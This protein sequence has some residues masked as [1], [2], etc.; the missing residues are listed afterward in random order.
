MENKTELLLKVLGPAL[1]LEDKRRLKGIF[2]MY[3]QVYHGESESVWIR[4]F[5]IAHILVRDMG[6]GVNTVLGSLVTGLLE[7][8]KAKREDVL[9]LVGPVA[10]IIADGLNQIHRLN[11][12][13]VSIASENFRRLLL[14][15]APDIRSLL[16]AMAENLHELQHFFSIDEERKQLALN[17]AQHIFIPFAH[18]LGLYHMKSQLEDLH[19]RYSLPEVYDNIMKQIAELKPKQESVFRSFIAPIRKALAV[20]GIPCEFKWRF[21]SIPSIY[22][23]MQK[24]EVPLEQVYDLFAIRII[25]QGQLEDEKAECWRV[26]S[27]VSDIYKPDTSRLRDWITRPKASGY[28]SLHTTVTTPEGRVVEVQIRT[29]R[30]DE[31]AEKGEAAHWRYKE[32]GRGSEMDNWM[33]EIRDVLE[34]PVPEQ[35]E[36]LVSKTRPADRIF[37]LTP[38]GD[39]RDLPA[40]ASVLDFAFDIHS[41]LGA[42]CTGARVNGRV[43]PI[44]HILSNGDVVEILTSRNQFPKIDW[45]QFCITSKARNRIKRA[46][47]EDRLKEAEKGKADLMRRCRNW[48]VPYTDELIERLLKYFKFK[49]ALDLYASLSKE[50]IDWAELKKVAS[51]G[52][53]AAVIPPPLPKKKKTEKILNAPDDAIV[54]GDNTRNISYTLAKCCSPIYGDD[55]FG[56][57][58]ISRGITIHRKNCPNAASLLSRHEYRIVEARWYEKAGEGPYTVQ[59]RITGDDRL[60]LLADLTNVLTNE[61][62]INILSVSLNSHDGFFDGTMKLQVRNRVQLD[63]V[64]HRLLKIK[65]VARVKR[66]FD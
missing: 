37:V 62:K 17:T 27:I 13:K 34:K 54:I 55:V 8:E 21:K 58:T 61:M 23:K 63:E 44:K 38:A 30:M 42:S 5:D 24:Q 14:S 59:L 28:E 45:L 32:S 26:Y 15:L 60:G 22:H 36:E 25:I 16:V 53:P 43:V 64:N 11:L 3:A 6:M 47:S 48:K 29:A 51:E 66:F 56:F 40:G 46:L 49:T 7:G 57:V 39:V 10:M 52:L 9:N 12:G 35:D 33:R 18:R 19:M 65:G 4:H 20:A 41:S 1:T 2:E 50:Q 31:I